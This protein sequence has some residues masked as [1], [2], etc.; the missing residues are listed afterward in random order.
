MNWINVKDKLPD[1][2]QH[3]NGGYTPIDIPFVYCKDK[4]I[5]RDVTYAGKMFSIRGGYDSF[6]RMG[7]YIDLTDR[8][9]HWIDKIEPP[10]SDNSK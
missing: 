2:K 4:G 5:I 8:V 9:T 6:M 7:T 3:P 1:S 10:I